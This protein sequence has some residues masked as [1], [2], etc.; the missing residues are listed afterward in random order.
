MSSYLAGSSFNIAL[1][2]FV[3]SMTKD[4]TLVALKGALV[5]SWHE[6]GSSDSF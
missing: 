3:L 2:A 1:Q 5:L 6:F 4:V